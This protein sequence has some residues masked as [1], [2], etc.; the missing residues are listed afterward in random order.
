MDGF[1]VYR[2][3]IVNAENE[4]VTKDYLEKVAANI[5]AA[6]PTYTNDAAFEQAVEEATVA[7]LFDEVTK[8]TKSYFVELISDDDVLAV[9]EKSGVSKKFNSAKKLLDAV[10]KDDFNTTV[11]LIVKQLTKSD[12]IYGSFDSVTA[13][14]EK[15]QVAINAV[16]EEEEEEEVKDTIT[17]NN[18]N[19]TS[20]GG[21]TYTPPVPTNPVIHVS[22]VFTDLDANYWWVINPLQTL[23]TKGYINGRTATTFAPGE[24]I[25]RAE[26]LKI[27]LL[28]LNMVDANATVTFSDV[29][30]NDW[31]YPYVASGAN[32]GI[33]MGRTA[34]EFAPNAQITREEICIMTMR[35]VRALNI[36]L[37]SNV[38]TGAFTDEADI[39]SYAV[40]DVH[41]LKAAGIVSGRDTG[42]FD[43]KANATRAEAVKIL[44]GVYE[45][46]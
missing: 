27:L 14:A 6:N 28:E 46:Q 3:Y 22:N 39:A 31:F 17:N 45:K 18:N 32:R 8:S 37:G 5:N 10:D 1:K 19:N 36:D 40:E 12:S 35:A 33:V 9:I 34:T 38:A 41:A 24:N 20:F 21:G 15:I 4:T 42:A 13:A 7:A 30:A 29:N 25:T 26:F 11:S 16:I 44:F 23:Y 2:K 43:P